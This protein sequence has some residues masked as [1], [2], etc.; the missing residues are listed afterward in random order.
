MTKEEHSLLPAEL[1]QYARDAL[2]VAAISDDRVPAVAGLMLAAAETIGEL[3]E[4]LAAA[5]KQIVA[6]HAPEDDDE[7]PVSVSIS[8][9][10]CRHEWDA[11]AAVGTRPKCTKCGAERRHVVTAPAPAAVTP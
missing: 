3:R 7:A 9:A 1:R 4:R 11:T 10:K 6:R 8:S 5:E 2:R